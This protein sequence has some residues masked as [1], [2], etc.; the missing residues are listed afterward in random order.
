MNLNM[1]NIHI[2]SIGILYSLS[3]A[4]EKK[5][6]QASEIPDSSSS[7]DTT[8]ELCHLAFW[9]SFRPASL[10]SCGEVRPTSAVESNVLSVGPHKDPV[11]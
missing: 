3:Y 9:S 2:K 4:W 1:L 10:Q 11:K 6:D 8:Y 7:S 5:L